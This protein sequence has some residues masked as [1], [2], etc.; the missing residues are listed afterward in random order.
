MAVRYPSQSPLKW[1]DIKVPGAWMWGSQRCQI[2]PRGFQIIARIVSLCPRQ[3]AKKPPPM[4]AMGGRSECVEPRAMPDEFL[5]HQH[6]RFVQGYGLYSTNAA[7]R[8][9]IPIP[10]Q[11]TR[12]HLDPCPSVILCAAFRPVKKRPSSRRKI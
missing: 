12:S 7:A 8:P 5:H 10:Y 6:P 11:K 9:L 4:T 2:D 1:S 3:K